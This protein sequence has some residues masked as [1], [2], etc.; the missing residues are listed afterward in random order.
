MNARLNTS[1][2]SFSLLHGPLGKLPVN[3]TLA[4]VLVHLT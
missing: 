2:L 4:R 3:T 1:Q